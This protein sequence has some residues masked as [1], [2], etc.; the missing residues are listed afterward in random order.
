MGVKIDFELIPDDEAIAQ[1]PVLFETFKNALG[2]SDH[3]AAVAVM[4]ATD[5]CPS[6]WMENRDCQCWND[7]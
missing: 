2:L 4:I 1:Y 5:V 7:E 6:C 3:K